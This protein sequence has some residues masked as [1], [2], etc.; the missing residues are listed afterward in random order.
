MGAI[1]EK[2]NVMETG[3]KDVYTLGAIEQHGRHVR[4][5]LC[6]LSGLPKTSQKHMEGSL[7]L[8]NIYMENST[9]MFHSPKWNTA[10]TFAPLL[11]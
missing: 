5:F 6:S 4:L 9:G 11:A 3:F 1:M 7:C 2:K 8:E 10:Q